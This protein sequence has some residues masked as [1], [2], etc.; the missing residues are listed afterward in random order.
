MTGYVVSDAVSSLSAVSRL[1]DAIDTI[2][3]DAEGV[4]VDTEPV[5]DDGQREFLGRRGIE[6]DRRTI[7]PLL[8][9][10]SLRDGTVALK[11]AFDLDGD[12]DSLATE[13]MEIVRDAFRDVGFVPGFLEFFERLEGRYKRCI[14]TSMSS[15]LLAIVDEHL[16]LLELFDG[17][18]FTLADVEN[19]SKP[20]PSL[21]LYAAG[22]LG[23]APAD[24]VVIED[25]PVGL[26]SAR[27]AGMTSIGLTTT[28]EATLLEEADVVVGSFE[29][30]WIP[31]A[32]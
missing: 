15:D 22:R 4:V 21:F 12:V 29:E 20:D 3:F 27:R 32:P 2:I 16:H 14:A 26:E 23:S 25:S 9:G 7:K 18:V 1:G 30:I 10:R 6:Y 28:Y 11:Q 31:K 24:C 8:T 17:C 19:R 13:R 5:W